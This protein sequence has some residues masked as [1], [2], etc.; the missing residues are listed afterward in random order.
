MTIIDCLLWLSFFI[1]S[2]IIGMLCFA[3]KDRRINEALY[4]FTEAEHSASLT[5]CAP[6]PISAPTHAPAP[7]PCQNLIELTFAK[8][9]TL[10]SAQLSLA[11]T[12]Y[13]SCD[14]VADIL[15]CSAS[16]LTL[17]D[18]NSE[19]IPVASSY[20]L[21]NPPAVLPRS[22][23]LSGRVLACGHALTEN[24]PIEQED[25]FLPPLVFSHVTS[26]ICA[27]LL[28]GDTILG[29]L[30]I[31]SVDGK[32]F[33]TRDLLLLSALARNAGTAI[34]NA[35]QYETIKLRLEEEKI[36]SELAQIGAMTLDPEAILTASADCICQALSAD[37]CIC[38]LSSTPSDTYH[39]ISP[40]LPHSL[41]AISQYPA[42]ASALSN[43]EPT[44]LQSCEIP[45]Y[46]EAPAGTSSLLL[47]LK[48]AQEPLGFLLC[49]M[50]DT[51]FSRYPFAKLIAR[52]IAF[53]LEKARLYNRVK[54]MALSDGLTG[55]A[56]R[57]NFDMLLKTELRRSA[58]LNRQLSLIMLDLDNFKTY[59]DTY[60]HLTGDK[61]LAQVG[62]IIHH[63]I[64]TIDLAARYGGEEFSI[65]LPEC[66]ASDAFTI[67]E[68]LR[69]TIETSH[70]PDSLGTF[71]A[72]ITAS[73]GIATYD[74]AVTAHSPDSEKIIALADKAL[75]R[76]K[77]SGRNRIVAETNL[78]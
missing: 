64:R 26:L 42:L 40:H 71:T 4:R 7:T 13:A 37:R 33:S 19:D 17:T 3:C 73:F 35:R 56:N 43:D 50:P 77:E 62:Q 69:T 32:Q 22:Q 29:T 34:E 72:A 15:G 51:S 68:K 54:S 9:G 53:C 6:T 24:A 36:L 76:A 12:L 10:L 41:I 52:Q 45:L 28:H 74:P 65:I 55:L 60:G 16:L 2:F 46:G 38:A 23:S 11:D 48:S 49:S 58:S 14:M 18:D 21:N 31:Y 66:S 57:R 59:N 5:A 20:G 25:L 8:T 1:I 70:F 75:Y 67:A 61:L 78:N 47:P 44:L 39:F 30:E 63:S 27:P